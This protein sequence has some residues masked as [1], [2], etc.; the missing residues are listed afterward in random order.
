M[1]G[2]GGL[3]VS[4]VVGGDIG[5]FGRGEGEEGVIVSLL[6]VLLWCRGLAVGGGGNAV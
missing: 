2:A 1:K 6:V 5:K 4:L 3:L